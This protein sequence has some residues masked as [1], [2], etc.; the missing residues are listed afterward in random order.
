MEL[1]LLA[2]SV[3]LTDNVREHVSARLAKLHRV[4]QD[5]HATRVE[6]SHAVTH[7]QGGV[8]KAQITAWVDRGILRAEESHADLFAAIDLAVD[9]MDRQVHR[10][11]DR[12]VARRH[13][14]IRPIDRTAGA[15]DTLEAREADEAGAGPRIRRRKRFEVHSMSEDEAAEQIELLGH[16]FYVFRN[17]RSGDIN[18]LYHR[19]SGDL[20]LIEPFQA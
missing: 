4:L 17:A 2:R 11:K 20:G 14:Q 16:D 7:S 1:E 10:F 9:K 19:K 6:L 3:D 15:A 5:I 13:G 8:F 12:R 18:V